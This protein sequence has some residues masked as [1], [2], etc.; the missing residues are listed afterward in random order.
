MS[1]NK[2]YCTCCGEEVFEDEVCYI[3]DKPYCQMCYDELSCVCDVCGT[4][5]LFSENRGNDSMYLCPNCYDS[6]YM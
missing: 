4:T 6:Y 2:I 3:D 1:K 5:F